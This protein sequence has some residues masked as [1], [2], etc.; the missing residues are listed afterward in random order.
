MAGG[1]K[2][3]KIP[4]MERKDKKQHPNKVGQ[5]LPTVEQKKREPWRQYNGVSFLRIVTRT[6]LL[7][8]LSTKIYYP[9][10]LD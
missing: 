8:L 10:F 3:K 7:M 1:G 2:G 5:Y 9:L 4:E 6:D